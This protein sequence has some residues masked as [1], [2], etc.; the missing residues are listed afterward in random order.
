MPSTIRELERRYRLALEVFI[1]LEGED[2]LQKAYEVGRD[3]ITSGLGVLELS[4]IHKAILCDLLARVHSPTRAA[5][6]VQRA[7]NFFSESLSPFEMTLRAFRENNDKLQQSLQQ[8]DSTRLA[9]ET[10]RQRY[11]AQFDFA[12]D[13]YFVTDLSGVIEEANVAAA[14]LL[15][16]K[17]D[18]LVS[19]PLSQFL[20]K[21]DLNTFENHLLQL[22]SGAIERVRDWQM[23][24]KPQMGR[25]FPAFLTVA[26]VRDKSGMPVGLRWLVRDITD[27]RRAET[28]RSDFLVRDKVARANAEGARRLAFLAEASTLLASSL[29]SETTL[30]S[31]AQFAVP[32]LADWCFV[33][34]MED[35]GSVRRLSVAHASSANVDL[36]KNLEEDGVA[37]CSRL[38]KQRTSYP[39]AR[40][41]HG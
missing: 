27:F 17:Q 18:V 37:D 13:G 30:G 20:N 41:R 31:V 10:E 39:Q 4:A 21:E 29:D 22:Q 11:R 25:P 40:N 38:G 3:L 7:M 2:A 1:E 9:V 15:H 5:T 33:Y 8:L 35:D 32:F 16:T 14:V 36:A 12:P 26:V 34:V 19:C 24:M 23:M 28:E 6:I